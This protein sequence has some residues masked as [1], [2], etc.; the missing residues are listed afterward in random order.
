LGAAKE[1]HL[2]PGGRSSCVKGGDGEIRGKAD[3]FGE[4]A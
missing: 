3:D 4:E 2:L 1:E